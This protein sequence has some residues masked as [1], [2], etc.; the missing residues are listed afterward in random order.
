MAAPIN[1]NFANR[2]NLVGQSVSIFGTTIDSTGEVG[3]PIPDAG[4]PLNSVWY[5]WTA[6]FSGLTNITTLGSTYDTSIGVYNG[7]AVNALSL[8]GTND[9]ISSSFRPNFVFPLNRFS[10]VSFQAVAGTTYQIQV[11]GFNADTGNLTLNISSGLISRNTTNGTLNLGTNLADI[12]FGDQSAN[13]ND[14]IAAFAGDDAVFGGVGNDS[15]DGGFGNDGLFGADGGDT[16]IG[17]IGN[18]TLTGGPGADRL[19]GGIGNDIFLYF[20][21]SEGGDIIQDFSS[22]VDSITFITNSFGGGLAVGPITEAQF[23]AGASVSIATDA[24]QRFLYDTNAGVLRFDP[25]GN[26]ANPSTI[27]ATLTGAPA[28]TRFDLVGV[29]S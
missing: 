24:T 8:V 4:N 20:L 12:I 1:D 9:D 3:E 28:I 15:I 22:G 27:L 7:N 21:P 5:S 18:D 25:D 13:P 19:I 2:I 26:G 10:L 11:D 16:L 23:L 17:N 6:P 14:T 29:A